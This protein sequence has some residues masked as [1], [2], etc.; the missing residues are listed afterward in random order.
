MYATV[1]PSLDKSFPFYACSIERNCW[2]GWPGQTVALSTTDKSVCSIAVESVLGVPDS[3][4]HICGSTSF[5]WMVRVHDRSCVTTREWVTTMASCGEHEILHI[6]TLSAFCVWIT[7]CSLGRTKSFVSVLRQTSFGE[8]LYMCWWWWTSRWWW[9]TWWQTTT[10]WL[11]ELFWSA[12]WPPFSLWIF[13]IVLWN[14]SQTKLSTAHS[15]V[16]NKT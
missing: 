9:T 6:P 16:H 13:L 4:E 3:A 12:Y 11:N 10:C 2:S 15:M 14:S 7:H 8:E 1:C 5:T